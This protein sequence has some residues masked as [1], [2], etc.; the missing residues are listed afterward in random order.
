MVRSSQ[1]SLALLAALAYAAPAFAWGPA[2]HEAVAQVAAQ[3]LTPF[4]QKQIATLL[5]GQPM[6]QV[7]TWADE[8]RTTTH[9][10]TNTWHYT[11]I[12]IT[13][14]GFT[15]ARDCRQGNC[16]VAAIERLE[17]ALRDRS[18]PRTER[19]EALRF[20]IHFVGDIHQPLHAGD[21]GDRGGGDRTIAPIGGV[22][23]LHFAWDGGIIRSQ[24]GSAASLASAAM[25]WLRTQVDGTLAAGSPA[26]WANESHRIARD[27]VYAQVKNDNAIAGTERFEA[28]RI[29]EKRI[30][31][32]GIRLAAVLNRAL[33]ASG[34]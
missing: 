13:S 5:G 26:D 32:S 17:A 23:N 29:I 10:H 6:W 34:T 22:T 18:R 1:L 14:T 27:V 12:P 33:G 2:G 28:L 4:V 30:A 19:Q 24:N 8:V 16:V 11:N 20:L 3:R 15:R 9:P 25:A 21:S 7:S 31:L